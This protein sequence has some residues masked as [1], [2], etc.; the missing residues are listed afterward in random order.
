MAL[1]VIPKDWM[2]RLV[3]DV[4]NDKYHQRDGH[5]SSTMVKKTREGSVRKA[6][7][8][9]PVDDDLQKIYNI[10]HIY[11]A[12]ITGDEDF[13][14]NEVAYFD[15]EER[16]VKERPVDPKDP[17]KG[18]RKAD[19]RTK[20]NAEWKK[21]WEKE[22]ADKVIVDPADFFMC[23]KMAKETM[24]DPLNRHF[25][26]KGV[27]QISIWCKLYGVKFKSRPDL[28]V[29]YD[30]DLRE[31]PGK[32]E[33]DVVDIKSAR[34]ASP[35]GFARSAASM[36]YL[37]QAVSQVMA[38]EACGYTVK[39]YFYLAGEKDADCPLA[40]LYEV[41]MHE[42]DVVGKEV[43]IEFMRPAFKK[44]MKKI[45]RFEKGKDPGNYQPKG[46]GS[47]RLETPGWYRFQIQDF[48]ND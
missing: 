1:E 35:G 37:I 34:D 43:S 38:V 5:W 15:P 27:S 29:P 23:E 3:F 36:D 48:L 8:K 14:R 46:G 42:Y 47:R 44:L 10:G 18:T 25:L 45:K 26:G 20:E 4:H 28:V 16:P 33:V 12:M 22:N 11:E 19:F 39:R 7:V 6:L 30:F 31:D 24:E 2:N 9:R 41:P 32:G 13:L 21:N 40:Q 17:S